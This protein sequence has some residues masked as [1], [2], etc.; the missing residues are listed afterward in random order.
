MKRQ[1][2]RKHCTDM[3]RHELGFLKAKLKKLPFFKWSYSMHAKQRMSQRGLD[4]DSIE[5]LFK[6]YRIMEFS[7]GIFRG[8]V[9]ARVRLRSNDRVGNV[10]VEILFSLYDAH[11]ITVCYSFSKWGDT[12]YN[13]YKKRFL[14]KLPVKQ[15]YEVLGYETRR[16]PA[17][18]LIYV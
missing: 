7:T 2:Q 14:K 16:V 9:D 18:S 8:R 3:T 6:S 4:F 17:H 11:I 10:Y 5:Q 15:A 1:L 12:Q 13:R